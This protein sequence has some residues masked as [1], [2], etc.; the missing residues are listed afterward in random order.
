MANY[1]GVA[2]NGFG[3]QWLHVHE[4]Q[5]LFHAGYPVPSAF[6]LPS[7]WVISAGGLPVPPIPTG[8]AR[9]AAIVNHYW[10]SLTD[11]ERNDPQWNPDNRQVW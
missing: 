10:G 3:R 8:N 11:E 9:R 2:A 1:E 7:G 5:A 6:R 4:A